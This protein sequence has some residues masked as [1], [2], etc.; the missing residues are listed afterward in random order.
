MSCSHADAVA[1][2][3]EDLNRPT[4]RR[5]KGFPCSCGARLDREQVRALYL[6][7]LEQH[8]HGRHQT[9]GVYPADLE[10]PH[11]TELG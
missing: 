1:R 11:R 6:T 10:I 8:K 2:Y 5:L 3:I 9:H 7:R 4:Q